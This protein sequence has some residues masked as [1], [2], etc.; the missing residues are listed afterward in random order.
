MS[1][2]GL[3]PGHCHS[4]TGSVGPSPGSGPHRK[5]SA[6]AEHVLEAR[7]PFGDLWHVLEL[8]MT[9]GQFPSSV[10]GCACGGAV[11]GAVVPSV[12]RKHRDVTGCEEAPDRERR[13]PTDDD[14]RWGPTQ[15]RWREIRRAKPPQLPPAAGRA[16][17]PPLP[18]LGTADFEPVLWIAPARDTNRKINCSVPFPTSGI[19]F[20][21]T[22]R[23]G[24]YAARNDKSPFVSAADVFP[25]L[26]S[27]MPWGCHGA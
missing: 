1:P 2:Q 8:S 11:G 14:W 24:E 26:L 23:I 12:L 21:K 22:S 17:S 9:P 18:L 25:W 13:P 10:L 19:K 3:Q 6:Q 5:T 27:G 16:S 7:C 20:L 4:S 15:G